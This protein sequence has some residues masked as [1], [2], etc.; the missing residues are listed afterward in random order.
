M[1]R[2][3]VFLVNLLPC[4]AFDD[5]VFVSFRRVA[6]IHFP[7]KEKINGIETKRWKERTRIYAC[8]VCKCVGNTKR[9][10]ASFVSPRN[11]RNEKIDKY[12]FCSE[13]DRIDYLFRCARLRC[14]LAEVCVSS[15]FMTKHIV[16]SLQLQHSAVSDTFFLHINPQFSMLSYSAERKC[17]C[18]N[19]A[20]SHFYR[21]IFPLFI[22]VIF[23]S[24]QAANSSSRSGR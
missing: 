9:F 3:Y 22:Y 17:G 24:S 15:G 1:N 2:F 12:L 14:E 18:L 16:A 11:M 20:L 23:Y 5:F 6:A 21:K 19:C 4:V 10:T 8:K 13:L 7:K